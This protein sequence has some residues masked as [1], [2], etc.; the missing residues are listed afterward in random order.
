MF[1]STTHR[2]IARNGLVDGRWADRLPQIVDACLWSLVVLAP[3]AWGGRNDASKFLYGLLAVGASLAWITQCWLRKEFRWTYSPALWIPALGAIGLILQMLPLPMEAIEWLSPRTAQLLP[4]WMSDNSSTLLGSDGWA[5]LSLHPQA[6]QTALAMLLC[7]SLVFFVA[8]QRLRKLEDISQLLRWIGVAAAAMALFGLA[9]YFTSNGRF[10][11]VIAHPHQTTEHFVCGA[12]ANRNHF[13]SFLAMGAAAIAYRLVRQTPQD[14]AFASPP[15]ASRTKTPVALFWTGWLALVGLAILMS[16]SRGGAMASAAGGVVLAVVYWRGKLWGAKQIGYLMAAITLLAIGLALYT[17]DRLTNRLDDL[18]SGSLEELDRLGGRRLIWKANLDAIADG[19]LTGSG[20]GTHRDIYPVYFEQSWP[21][22]FT[23]AENGYLQIATETGL[24]GILLL[25]ATF[26]A[27]VK[28]SLSA[29]RRCESREAFACLGA[30]LAAL[31]VSAVHS[32]VDFVWYTPATMMLV[33]LLLAALC[34][35]ANLNSS[36]NSSDSSSDKPLSRQRR[37]DLT[38]ALGVT[39]AFLLYVMAGPALA[40]RAWNQYYTH[41]VSHHLLQAPQFQQLMQTGDPTCLGQDQ[42]F[43]EAKTKALRIAV[44]A[45]P[46]SAGAHGRLART[47]LQWFDARSHGRDNRMGLSH[48]Q[49]T[50]A[51]GGFASAE[52]IDAWLRRAVGD[53]IELLLAARRH[54]RRAVQLSP[55]EGMAYVCLAQLSFLDDPSGEATRSYFAQ[56]AAVRPYDGD[57]LF[58]IGKFHLVLR[59]IEQ[60]LDYWQR[61]YRKEGNHRLLVIAALAGRIPAQDFLETFE[62]DWK[63][64]PA[65][66][67]R[68]QPTGREPDLDALLAYAEK[69]TEKYSP[70]PGDPDAAYVWRWLAQMHA[71]RG[72]FDAELKCL[73]RAMD[74]NGSLY[75]VRKSLADALFRAERFAE[76]EPHFRWCLAR[77]PE[78]KGMRQALHQAANARLKNRSTATTRHR[79]SRSLQR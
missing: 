44:A 36:D 33:V 29:L 18:T 65:V 76:S 10:F 17:D 57:I 55:L 16:F 31:T 24:P 8:L 61:C 6:T 11:W 34:R 52:E 51:S 42:S 19:W 64:L 66:W 9:Q 74:E 7:Y 32:L 40:A 49:A 28:W 56:A 4:L 46:R 22:V 77:H 68:Y 15:M 2:P 38:L 43:F 21:K 78:N 39:A 12:F 37:W 79:R 73:E 75:P 59:E 20:A 25:V 71:D 3:F 41:S 27:V 30:L 72:D 54:A 53:D 70:G 35:L 26:L 62:P 50:V 63:T 13:A 58:E 23:H 47:Y 1:Q 67:Q 69:Q 5:T 14:K 45:E 60:A 48:L